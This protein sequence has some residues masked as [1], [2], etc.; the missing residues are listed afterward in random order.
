MENS[1]NELVKKSRNRWLELA[2][3]KISGTWLSRQEYEEAFNLYRQQ[4]EWVNLKRIVGKRC[5]YICERCFQS[6]FKECHHL[7]YERVFMEKPEDLMGVCRK[8]HLILESK[9]CRNR[10]SVQKNIFLKKV[11]TNKNMQQ[12]YLGEFMNI[13]SVSQT[14]QNFIELVRLISKKDNFDSCELG[15]NYSVGISALRHM[16]LLFANGRTKYEVTEEL[17]VVNNC[18]DD[19]LIKLYDFYSKELSKCTRNFPNAYKSKDKKKVLAKYRHKHPKFKNIGEFTGGIIP[20]I[21]DDDDDVK[22]TETVNKKETEQKNEIAT[23]VKSQLKPEYKLE[24]LF[25]AFELKKLVEKN[26]GEISREEAL[27]WTEIQQNN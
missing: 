3:K 26:G 9:K 18:S 8:C 19:Q 6:P 1:L 17:K 14:K 27:K 2:K 22:T 16:G 12:L 7:I 15:K 10:K 20:K 24:Q 21:D 4:D 11:E 5:N 13:D 23:N 25:N